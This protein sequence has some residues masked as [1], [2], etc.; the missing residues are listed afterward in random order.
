LV[1]VGYISISGFPIF[2]G[3]DRIDLSTSA[4]GA[5]YVTHVFYTP[6]THALTGA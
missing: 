1:A 6:G 2:N 5:V 4:S 3:G